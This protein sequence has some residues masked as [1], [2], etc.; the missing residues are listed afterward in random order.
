MKVCIMN[1]TKLIEDLHDTASLQIGMWHTQNE[2]IINSA[3]ECIQTLLVRAERAEMERDAAVEQLHGNCAACKHY[4]INP[5]EGLCQD[6]KY[7]YYQYV[8]HNVTDIWQWVGVKE[9]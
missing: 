3:A 5:A 6:C 1:Y 9:V 4:T 2:E 7:E 8:D